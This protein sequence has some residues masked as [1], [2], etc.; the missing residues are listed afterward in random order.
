MALAGLG[1]VFNT[2]KL[3]A[4]EFNA[5]ALS[6]YFGRKIYA[7]TCLLHIHLLMCFLL[8]VFVLFVCSKFLYLL[9]VPLAGIN[10][11]LLLFCLSGAASVMDSL[12]RIA[13]AKTL[14]ARP[15]ATSTKAGVSN[16]PTIESTLP[17][18]P[19]P[20]TTQTPNSPH[21]LQT[22]NS[23][24]P[25]AAVP[26]AVA[27]TSAPAPLDKGKG[28][29]VVPSDDKGSGEGQVF[30]RG[31]INR[32]VTSRSASPQ[33]RESLR[34]NPPSATSPPPQICQEE[35]AESTPPPSQTAP[36]APAPKLLTIPPAIMQLMR[37]F[38]ERSSGSS[39][40]EAKKEDMPYY[41]GAFLAI[42]LDWRAQAKTKAIETQTLQA[43]K[44]EVATLKDEK[45]KLEDAFQASLAET[46]KVEEAATLRLR[47]ADQKHADLLDSMAPLQAEVAELR[48]VAETSKALGVKMNEV[49]GELAA[50]T[51]AFNLLQAEYDKSQTE[52]NKLQVEK[53]FLV[54]QLAT[55][56]SKIEELEK[57]NYTVPS[58]K[59]GIA[60]ERGISKQGYRQV[61]ALPS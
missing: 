15:K 12:R 28:V 14:R 60:Q 38:N 45:L 17:P 24:P 56:D 35:G 19:T 16:I 5:D 49:E 7:L 42:A 11:N 55:K 32:V 20:H 26:L 37:G 4:C 54:K 51:E 36:Q 27:H 47:D 52:V 10:S 8:L 22:A 61:K 50:K 1:V 29:L 25:I 44:R 57:A 18:S 59:R 43:L 53:E 13:L 48:E 6:R 30:K 34:D 9:H 46:R 31:R 21:S 39:S 3:I 33:C 41:M 2:A 58:P 23:P 40:G